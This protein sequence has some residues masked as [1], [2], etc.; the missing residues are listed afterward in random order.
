VLGKLLDNG[1]K[2]TEAGEVVL[3]VRRL[4][5]D[6]GR[7]VLRVSDT[8][9]GFEP[10]MADRLF[11]PFEQADGS[12]TR[13]FGGVGLGLAICRGLVDLMGG[14]ITAQG[15][16]GEGAVFCVELPLAEIAQAA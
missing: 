8:G 14:V 7:V 11:R 3:S 2:F 9:V 4:E 13:R 1:V 6:A 15:K 16:P 10:S 5:G 12:L